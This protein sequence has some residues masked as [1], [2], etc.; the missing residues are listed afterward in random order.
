[1][2]DA[3]YRS[4]LERQARWAAD[5]QIELDAGG[6]ARHWPDNLFA[7]L[8]DE[9]LAE[10]EASSRRPFGD[11]DKPG[12]LHGLHSTLALVASAFGYWRGRSAA[13][14]ADALGIRGEIKHLRFATAH[15]C[16]VDDHRV[17]LDV[18]IESESAHPA[19]LAVWASYAEPYQRVDPRLP[20][21]L[22]APGRFDAPLHGCQ[23][24]ADDLRRNPRRYTRRAVGARLERNQARAHT[25]GPQD[26]RL[27]VPGHERPGRAAR[28]L[29]SELARLRS[30]IGGEVRLDVLTWRALVSGIA[31]NHRA[32][33]AYTDYLESRYL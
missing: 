13:P 17:E 15:A 22:R 30:R 33:L 27:L 6:Q 5:A 10:L 16:G 26:Y 25:L 8:D 19:R 32:H 4:I 29:R 20:D 24:L 1:M 28:E 11:G 31:R 2:A 21:H 18:E 23:Q 9:S 3:D 12:P 7:P 14:L